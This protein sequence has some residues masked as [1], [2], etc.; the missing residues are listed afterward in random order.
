MVSIKIAIASHRVRNFNDGNN[1]AD[2][3]QVLDLIEEKW[4]QGYLRMGKL[5][6][7]LES[8]QNNLPT[9]IL[10]TNFGRMGI[11]LPLEHQTFTKI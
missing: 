4:D 9:D 8:Q 10:A 2:H 3:K 5:G 7:S 6:R 1:N 11:I